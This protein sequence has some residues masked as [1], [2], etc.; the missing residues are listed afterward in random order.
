MRHDLFC[1]RLRTPDL[2]R[3][4]VQSYLGPGALDVGTRVQAQ[5]DR[6]IMDKLSAQLDRG[7][8][9]L[10]QGRLQEA[11]KAATYAL[12]C[13]AEAAEPYYLQGCVWLALQQPGKAL[14]LLEQAVD[15]DDA[16]F[17]AFLAGADAASACGQPVESVLRWLE[18]ASDVAETDDERQACLLRRA[19]VEL[20]AGLRAVAAQHVQGALALSIP[21]E[22]EQRAL[23]LR[24]A[25]ELELWELAEPVAEAMRKSSPSVERELALG[26]LSESRG[27][28]AEATLHYAEAASLHQIDLSAQAAAG[29][30]VELPSPSARERLGAQLREQLSPESLFSLGSAPIIIGE[31]PPLELVLTGID[32]RVPAHIDVE[33]ID[34]AG[35]EARVSSQASS[36]K[37]G[38]KQSGAQRQ[39]AGPAL[40]EAEVRFV[41]IYL[42][43][44]Q[45]LVLGGQDWFEAVLS[46]LEIELASPRLAREPLQSE[47]DLTS[48]PSVRK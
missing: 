6:N 46:T 10:N 29:R 47:A 41:C 19:D 22:I 44:L 32:P 2:D 11:L 1:G 18:S 15:L 43:N 48:Q 45:S 31:L 36:V 16:F 34:S 33:E 35:E 27:R 17:E 3:P 20:G 30:A 38:V 21:E 40:A 42:R 7:W 26:R 5:N 4:A 14:E 25:A 28:L 24:L 23:L 12:G 8:E 13:D 37:M 9:Q 39:G